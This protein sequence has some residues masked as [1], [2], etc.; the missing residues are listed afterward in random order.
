MGEFID[1]LEKD[2]VFEKF[3]VLDVRKLS[4]SLLRFVTEAAQLTQSEFVILDCHGGPDNSSFAACLLADFSILVSEPD[5]IT[6][7]GTLHF[8]RKLESVKGNDW[9]DIRLVFNKVV[10]GFSAFYLTKFYDRH[11]RDLFD[12]RPL[13]AIFPLEVYLTKE[14]EKEPLLT[15]VYPNSFLAR[16][17]QQLLFDLLSE[18]N[19]ELLSPCIRHLPSWIRKFRKYALGRSNP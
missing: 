16:K 12:G 9:I 14:F 17:T 13:L 5:R 8:L 4:E 6:F 19:S 2:S 1:T 11:I 10:A 18:R 15:S 7:Y 3:E